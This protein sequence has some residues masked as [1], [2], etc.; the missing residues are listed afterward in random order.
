VPEVRAGR[1]ILASLGLLPGAVNIVSCP[2]CARCKADLPGI[3]AE[4]E[5]AAEGL[6]PGRSVTVAVMGCAVNG[7]GEAAHADVGVAGGDGSAVLFRKGEKVRARRTAAIV[8]ALMA[9]CAALA[10][11]AKVG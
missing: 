4:V 2:T 6:R 3:V 1:D 8:P 5:K 9:E 10:G 7:P 11:D